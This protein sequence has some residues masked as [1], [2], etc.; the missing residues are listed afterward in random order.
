MAPTWAVPG[1]FLGI[2]NPFVQAVLE[3]MTGT[4]KVG[5]IVGTQKAWLSPSSEES[6]E[7]VQEAVA[8]KGGTRF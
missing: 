4:N 7:G 2:T 5:S 1:L 6:S 8:C 3:G